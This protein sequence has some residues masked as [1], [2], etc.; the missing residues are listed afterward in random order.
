MDMDYLQQLEEAVMAELAATEPDADED[1]RGFDPTLI[2][3]IIGAIT[4]LIQMCRRPE[5]NPNTPT[6]RALLTMQ[7]RQ[8]SREHD[9]NFRRNKRRLQAVT[10]KV[11]DKSTPEQRRGLAS[12]LGV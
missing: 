8:E 7:L 2:T 1:G 12:Q 11:C 4:G 3:V 9:L 6:G 5:P 10:F